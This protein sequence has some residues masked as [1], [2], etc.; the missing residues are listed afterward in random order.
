VSRPPAV[1]AT[2]LAALACLVAATFGTGCGSGKIEVPKQETSLHQGPELF[3][4]RFSVCHSLAA[5]N[6]YGSKQ[7]EQKQ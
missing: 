4:Q 7:P 6:A 3:N 1:T 5:A 2:R